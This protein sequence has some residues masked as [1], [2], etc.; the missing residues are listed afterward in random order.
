MRT[1][2]MLLLSLALLLISSEGRVVPADMTCNSIMIQ[3]GKQCDS[4]A[5]DKQCKYDF[6]GVGQCVAEG[7]KCYYCDG[8]YF[9]QGQKLS[10][11]SP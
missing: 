5:C 9:F 4:D 2:H 1:R 11:L 8:S 6:N 3:Q 10:L 7:C